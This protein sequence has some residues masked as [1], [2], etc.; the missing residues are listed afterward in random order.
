[1]TCTLFLLGK[2]QRDSLAGSYQVIVVKVLTRRIHRGSRRCVLSHCSF[3]GIL[4]IDVVLYP[5]KEQ[6]LHFCSQR[7]REL[8]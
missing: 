4:E 1:M 2:L 7:T 5:E 6:S 8:S 3:E